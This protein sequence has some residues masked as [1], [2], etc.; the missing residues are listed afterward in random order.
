MAAK[1]AS[2][3]VFQEAMDEI[4]TRFIDCMPAGEL[5]NTERLGFALEKAYWYYIDF[6]VQANKCA[7]LTWAAFI[8]HLLLC[9]P[10]I[11][12]T[13]GNVEAFLANFQKFKRLIPVYGLVML[14]HDLDAVLLVRNIGSKR[15][16]Y[17]KGKLNSLETPFQCAVRE[18]REET[19][20][21]VSSIAHEEDFVTGENED[22]A[23]YLVRGVPFDASFAPRVRNEIEEIKWFPIEAEMNEKATGSR[24]YLPSWSAV[25]AWIARQPLLSHEHEHHH[26]DFDDDHDPLHPSPTLPLVPMFGPAATTPAAAP[27]SV[28]PVSGFGGVAPVTTPAPAPDAATAAATAAAAPRPSSASPTRGPGGKFAFNMA[29]VFARFDAAMKRT[30]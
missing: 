12:P 28:A 8:K 11:A 27:V 29:A 20:F 4:I 19:G 16:S 6:Y 10:K 1:S 30:L 21:D 23:Y 14:S 17:P 26:F 5:T 13:V 15:F 18:G 24:L 3:K 22:R 7:S 2:E 25:R 9:V